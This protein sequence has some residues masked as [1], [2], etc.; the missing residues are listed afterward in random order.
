[1]VSRNLE[2][3]N[4]NDAFKMT[5]L[6]YNLAATLYPD[7]LT[8]DI[9]MSFKFPDSKLLTYLSSILSSILQPLFDSFL[10]V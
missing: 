9:F 3:A 4:E 2:R 7:L 10:Y 6:E 8:A 5:A 1:M